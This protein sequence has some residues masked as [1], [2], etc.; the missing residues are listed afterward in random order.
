[1]L[2]EKLRHSGPPI[3]VQDKGFGGRNILFLYAISRS[4][5]ARIALVGTSFG[6]QDERA[7]SPG[8]GGSGGRL[9]PTLFQITCAVAA[10]D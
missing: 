2:D 4:S 9:P 10:G 5:P 1:M 7:D 6:V 3:F 8:G